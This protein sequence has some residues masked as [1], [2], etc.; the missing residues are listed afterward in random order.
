[1]QVLGQSLT[2]AGAAESEGELYTED[3]L[4]LDSAAEEGQQHDE[5]NGDGSAMEDGEEEKEV[6]RPSARTRLQFTQQQ[7][8][9]GAEDNPG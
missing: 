6:M 8:D 1:M 2:N 4:G 9:E 7:Y 3:N 5:R